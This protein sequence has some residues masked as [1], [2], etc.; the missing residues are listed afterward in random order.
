VLGEHGPDVSEVAGRREPAVAAPLDDD[1]LA[2]AF[3]AFSLGLLLGLDLGDSLVERQLGHD[4]A[5]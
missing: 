4:E 1:A 2:F 3:G 5:A